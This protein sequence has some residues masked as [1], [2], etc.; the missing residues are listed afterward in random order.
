MMKKRESG[1]FYYIENPGTR[2]V[3]QVDLCVFIMCVCSFSMSG[4]LYNSASTP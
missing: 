1:L 4:V 3:E 2:V